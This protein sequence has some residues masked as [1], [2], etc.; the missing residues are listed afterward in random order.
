MYT[1]RGDCLAVWRSSK[2]GSILE[3]C[4]DDMDLPLFLF[5]SLTTKRDTRIIGVLRRPV[6]EALTHIFPKAIEPVQV[7]DC[8]RFWKKKNVNL[9][10]QLPSKAIHGPAKMSVPVPEVQ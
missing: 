10:Y 6:A 3:H 8:V 7:I 4:S 5:T 1:R 9:L 2:S